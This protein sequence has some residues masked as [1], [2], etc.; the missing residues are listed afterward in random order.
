MSGIPWWTTDIGGYTGGDAADP[1]YRDTIV[2][3]FQFGV[4][5]PLFRQHGHRRGKAGDVDAI[6]FYGSE[7]EKILG[8]IIKLRA[9]MK[10]YFKE[11]LAK[12]TATGRPFNRP[13]NWDFPDT[14]WPGNS[15]IMGSAIQEQ[16]QR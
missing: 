16:D 12:L 6:W 11:Q 5:N 14:Q 13:L 3:W 10:P 9:S 7:D 4:T 1:T 8:D 15:L 2:R